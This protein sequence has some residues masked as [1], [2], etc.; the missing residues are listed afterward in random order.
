MNKYYLVTYRERTGEEERDGKFL[1]LTADPDKATDAVLKRFY[2]VKTEQ[3]K[4]F[5]EGYWRPDGCAV[6][7]GRGCDKIS[8][9]DAKVL[10]KHGT[11]LLWED[12]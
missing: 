4:A 7:T 6:V 5:G 9:A 12:K 8:K 1:V 10:M 2:G 3:V 11:N